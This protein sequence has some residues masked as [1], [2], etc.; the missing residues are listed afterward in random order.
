M[1]D[2]DLDLFEKELQALKP[3]RPPEALVANLARTIANPHLH[4]PSLNPNLNPCSLPHIGSPSPGG[5]GRR[6]RGHRNLSIQNFTAL[7]TQLRVH[8][9]WL[10]PATALVLASVVVL[11]SN[12]LGPRILNS[13]GTPVDSA[14]ALKADDVKIDSTLVSSYDAVASLPDGEPVRFR[15]EEWVDEVRLKD[16]SRGLV[17]SQKVPRV[18]VVPVCFETY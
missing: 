9:R 18:T 10:I 2:H 13:A 16:S 4:N 12:L 3:S 15:C 14:A 17:Y 1:S 8:L 7:V 6:E 11:R 5:E